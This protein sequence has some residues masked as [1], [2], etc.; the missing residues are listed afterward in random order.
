MIESGKEQGACLQAGGG[1]LGDK[2]YFIKPTVFSDVTD[3]MRIAKE[4]VNSP[5][6]IDLRDK[7]LVAL[8]AMVTGTCNT[9]TL[10]TLCRHH[11]GI[12]SSVK[13]LCGSLYSGIKHVSMDN[14]IFQ[15]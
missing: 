14:G 6:T 4:E 9:K 2:G 13:T 7:K 5:W 11:L 15:A 10:L 1:R 8:V 12:T 3:E